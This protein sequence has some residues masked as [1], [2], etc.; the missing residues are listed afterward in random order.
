[1]DI[2]LLQE[3]LNANVT[4]TIVIYGALDISGP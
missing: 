3:A 2:F 4:F 1:M